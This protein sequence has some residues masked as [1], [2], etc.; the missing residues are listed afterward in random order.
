MTTTEQSV[1]PVAVEADD[2]SIGDVSNSLTDRE[3]IE[4]L[5]AGVQ[6]ERERV[7]SQAKEA[8]AA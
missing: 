6:S 8:V 4:A 5:I 7:R 1:Q 3:M 2:I